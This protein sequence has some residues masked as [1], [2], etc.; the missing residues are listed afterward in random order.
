MEELNLNE[1]LNYYLKKL[2]IIVIVTLLSLIAGYIY[3]EEVQIPM[4]HGTTTIILVERQE[5]DET[6][7]VTQNELL[8]NEK[9]VS[10]YSQIIKSR[11]V[12]EQVIDDL[13]LKDTTGSLAERIEVTAVTDTSIIK[14]SVSDE[15]N[16]K[17]VKI[18]NKIAEIFKEEVTDIYNL[19]NV[20]IIDKAIVE[21]E[22][23]NVSLLKQ[24]VICALAG[25]VLSCGLI[26]VMF[27]FDNT[28]KN[29]KE[30]EEKLNLAVLGE[31]PTAKKL[32]KNHRK[33]RRKRKISN[34]DIRAK[35]IKDDV[36]ANVDNDIEVEDTST[37]KKATN[38]AAKKKN[39]KKVT[40]KNET[41]TTKKKSTTK[42]STTKTKKEE[43]E[44]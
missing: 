42:K 38:D 30:I 18:V 39:T 43:G 15:N 31:I 12:L 2:P 41:K 17:A 4:Y 35:D 40:Y 26:F 27:Y 24:L 25:I 37:K 8:I 7:I 32:T 20:S 9:L 33:T 14:V 34:D 22:P 13:K 29:K 16:K 3:T 44:K 19:E 28:I 6:S 5:G 11:R 1:L 21:D 23:Y 36:F 10:T